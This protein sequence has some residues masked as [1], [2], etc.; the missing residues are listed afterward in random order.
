MKNIYEISNEGSPGTKENW[1]EVYDGNGDIPNITSTDLL[2]L[3]RIYDEL[4][5]IFYTRD[6]LEIYL[7]GLI[8]KDKASPNLANKYKYEIIPY[9]SNE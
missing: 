2:E 9:E 5:A 7:E 4:V 1:Y 3:S 6:E 8:A